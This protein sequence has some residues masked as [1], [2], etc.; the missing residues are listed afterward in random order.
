[1]P[2][3]SSPRTVGCGR[4]G[5]RTG[6]NACCTDQV[7]DVSDEHRE[8]TARQAAEME[9]KVG[10]LLANDVLL[11]GAAAILSSAPGNGPVVCAMPVARDN[12]RMRGNWVTGGG[13][14]R[15]R[16]RIRARSSRG[17]REVQQDPDATRSDGPEDAVA[18][19]AARAA[20]GGRDDHR[21]GRAFRDGAEGQPEIAPQGRQGSDGGS[22]GGEGNAVE[23]RCWRPRACR[24][25]HRDGTLQG[26]LKCGRPALRPRAF[27]F[28]NVDFG[29]G[30][31]PFI[32]KGSNSCE[33]W[34]VL[35]GCICAGANFV[36]K[37]QDRQ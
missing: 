15:S 28:E 18:A 20:R 2:F 37:L 36:P 30:E 34:R 26:I 32:T 7:E 6:A 11:A 14:R 13:C 10:S 8:L 22:R 3:S 1:M 16:L 19:D 33:G 4:Q 35:H 31:K 29:S 25:P 21:Q 24:D 17:R 12:G 5:P 23:S 27:D 9:E